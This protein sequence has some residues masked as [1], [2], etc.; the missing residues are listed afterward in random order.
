MQ[1][2][3][4]QD[5]TTLPRVNTRNNNVQVKVHARDATSQERLPARPPPPPLHPAR[6]AE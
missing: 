2:T 4:L 1:R 5:S 6:A 3:K